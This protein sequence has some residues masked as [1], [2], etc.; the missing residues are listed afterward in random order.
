MNLLRKTKIVATLGPATANDGVLT[1]LIAA[2]VNVCRLNF[3]HGT[4]D[5][6]ADMLAAVR[7]AAA[8]ADTP[9][10]VLG[11]LCGPKIRLNR[12]MGGALMLP[13]GQV[14]RFVRG[15][16]ECTAETLTTTYPHLLDEVDIGHR[17]Y[18]DDGLVRLLVIER[19]P[20]AL[21]CVV[22]DGGEISTRKGVNLPDS[23]LSVPAMTEK[24]LADLAWAVENELDFVALSFVRNAADLD[25]LH[26]ALDGVAD[27]ARPAI[28]AKIE[29]VEAVRGLD[30][31]LARCDGV[32]VARGD[33]GVETD[34]WQVP[35]IQKRILE[36][37]RALRKPAIVATQ[38]LQSMVDHPTPTRA[39]VADVAN[40][41]LDGADAVMLSA[42][43]SVGK[44]PVRAVGMM[45]RVAMTTEQ[46]LAETDGVLPPP[47]DAMHGSETY[48][49]ARA[50]VEAARSLRA[51]LVAAWTATGETVRLIAKHRLA[52][53]VVGLTHDPR[54]CRRM[55]LLF[56]VIPILVEPISNP[57][58]MAEVLDGKLLELKLAKP[59]DLTAVVTSTDPTHPGTTDTVLI[60][61]V[62]GD[63]LRQTPG[64]A[65]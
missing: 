42:E 20:D 30:G 41:I 15:D 13:A 16:A 4:L 49:I 21:V 51:K 1:E 23:P 45:T 35:I 14:V 5:Q 27:G 28:I 63:S 6:H 12:V 54:V 32:M 59:A 17:V 34:V 11:D 33:L 58:R 25:A 7:R 62:G 37:C 31:I 9:V 40:A 26:A 50:G 8:K 38:M 60:H 64:A 46:Y 36:R 55:N 65:V 24:D 57:A 53:P 52:V 48:A 29:K 43:T 19:Q 18:I 10:A 2:G 44:Y 47:D 3:S 39:E 22:K 56:G 61:R